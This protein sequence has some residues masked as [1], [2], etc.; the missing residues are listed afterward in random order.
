MKTLLY[1]PWP[2]GLGGGTAKDLGVP[3]VNH[4]VTNLGTS[5]TFPPPSSGA[6]GFPA[7][8]SSHSYP[9]IIF[10]PS[11]WKYFSIIFLFCNAFLAEQ[12]QRFP[13][14]ISMKNKY[15]HETQ[16]YSWNIYMKHKY[17]HENTNISMRHFHETKNLSV[18]YNII[19]FEAKI[20]NQ[21]I[22][23]CISLCEYRKI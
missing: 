22:Q 9:Y 4:P 14:D 23:G 3:K 12:T 11:H 10:V 2:A 6:A 15:S 8:V 19:C 5:W 7:P 16:I 13:W 1:Y 18:K 20:P 21:R 17:F